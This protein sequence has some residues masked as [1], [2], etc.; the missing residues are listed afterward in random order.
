MFLPMLPLALLALVQVQLIHAQ[1]TALQLNTLQNFTAATLPRSPVFSLPDSSSLSVSVAVCGNDASATPR[2]F[3]TNDTAIT[4]PGPDSGDPN[5]FELALSDG[6]GNWTGD[7]SGGGYLSVMN[8]DQ[9]PFEIGVSDQGEQ[10][11]LSF[12]LSFWT[13]SA[14]PSSCVALRLTRSLIWA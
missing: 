14:I 10:P 11:Y 3:V 8:A 13:I 4:Q 1:N 9:T 7:A 12:C 2:F 6:W 5:V